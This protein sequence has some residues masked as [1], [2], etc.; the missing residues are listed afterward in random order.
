M[1]ED[2]KGKLL[3]HVERNGQLL[4][5]REAVSE[6]AIPELSEVEANADIG[7]DPELSDTGP[8]T[9]QR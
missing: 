3:G 7:L 5:V 1:E 8:E 6:E 2:G 9:T 4:E